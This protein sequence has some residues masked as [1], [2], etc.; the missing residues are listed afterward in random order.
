LPAPPLRTLSTRPGNERDRAASPTSPLIEEVYEI[1]PKD[2]T[3]R[4][5]KASQQQQQQN[6]SG[7]GQ[8]KLASIEQMG[9]L[10][11]LMIE[12]SPQP[13]VNGIIVYDDT[14]NRDDITA[15]QDVNSK[16]RKLDDASDLYDD[17]LA[18]K[19]RACKGKRYEQFMTPTKK[20][21]K[22][23]NA[24]ATSSSSASSTSSL[25]PTTITSVHFP[26]NGYC[27]PYE[28]K[29]HTGDSSDE[30]MA[31]SPESDEAEARNADASDFKLNDKIMTLPSLDLDD[32]LNRKKAMK[33][34]KKFSREYLNLYLINL[35]LLIFF[36]F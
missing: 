4:N 12:S 28:M 8:F 9:G 29:N 7:I 35:N 16:K 14:H 19:S 5:V 3:A 15:V 10:S 31:H 6:N 34:K 21:T 24:N 36:S 33:K 20:A 27:K 18:G 2:R 26:H 32:Y 1:S 22:Q 17:E 11:S 25:S 30:Q 23:K 13:R